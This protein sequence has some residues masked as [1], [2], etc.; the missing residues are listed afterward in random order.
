MTVSLQEARRAIGKNGA[1]VKRIR[2]ESKTLVQID[3][4]S[5]PCTCS[6]SGTVEAVDRARAMVFQV[7][8]STGGGADVEFEAEEYLKV[9]YAE[10]K[11]IVGKSGA[12]IKQIEKDTWAKVEVEKLDHHSHLVR[13]S[14]SFD[15][16]DQALA[17]V[18]EAK[19]WSGNDSGQG[20]DKSNSWS[21]DK[22]DDWD[23]KKDW[24]NK[25]K[26]D[27]WDK[28]GDWDTQGGGGG[29]KRKWD[30]GSW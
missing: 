9:T 22:K 6:I 5:E 26:K 24:D 13:V 15:A 11:R 4:E 28:K 12:T 14:G 27:D 25:D 8:R 2:S 1:M 10:S 20:W 19:A 7:M 23:K 21:K 3:P 18:M 29:T 16:V 30:A 17:K